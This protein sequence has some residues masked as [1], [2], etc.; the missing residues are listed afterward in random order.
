MNRAFDGGA[1][2]KRCGGAKVRERSGPEARAALYGSGG[3]GGNDG[4]LEKALE[5]AVRHVAHPESSTNC[6]LERRAGAGG[7]RL[8]GRGRGEGPG[9]GGA[10]AGREGP[11]ARVLS[12]AARAA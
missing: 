5:S 11:G 9:A 7:A 3:R 10:R 12:E 4:G 6:A 2:A 1:D 8:S